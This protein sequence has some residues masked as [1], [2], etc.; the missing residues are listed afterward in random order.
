MRTFLDLSRISGAAFPAF[1]AGAFRRE[2]LADRID[3]EIVI[4]AAV[5]VLDENLHAIVLPLGAVV[6]RVQGAEVEA[7]HAEVHDEG[8][9][10]A[11][12]A[13]GAQGGIGKGLRPVHLAHIKTGSLEFQ[14]FQDIFSAFDERNMD[15]CF[16]IYKDTHLASFMRKKP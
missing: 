6:F 13:A 7:A 15:C 5:R 1:P 9:L 12:D 10:G 11:G 4:F 3:L 8:V 16:H 14:G 2:D